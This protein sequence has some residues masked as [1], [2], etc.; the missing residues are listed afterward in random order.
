MKRHTPKTKKLRKRREKA[1][2][3][4]QQGRREELQRRSRTINLFLLGYLGTLKCLML[5]DGLKLTIVGTARNIPTRWLWL[6][7]RSAKNT[8]SAHS[9]KTLSSSGKRLWMLPRG[10]AKSLRVMHKTSGAVIATKP[11]MM[12]MLRM[13]VSQRLKGLK[14]SRRMKQRLAKRM[15]TTGTARS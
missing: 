11:I 8:T 3:K 10:T 5:T 9:E 12:V 2:L 13:M 14:E 1:S 6:A 15:T 4:K 7:N